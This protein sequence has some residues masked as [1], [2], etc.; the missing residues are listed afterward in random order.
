MIGVPVIAHH[1]AAS[2][3]LSNLQ[4]KTYDLS[5]PNNLANYLIALRNCPPAQDAIMA[6]ANNIEQSFSQEKLCQQFVEMLDRV[7]TSAG[8]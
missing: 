6:L 8:K 5:Q 2:Q 4:F 7:T 3:Q 1:T